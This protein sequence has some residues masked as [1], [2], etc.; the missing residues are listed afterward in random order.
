M[1]APMHVHTAA[2]EPVRMGTGF[3]KSKEESPVLRAEE[4]DGL[5]CTTTQQRA[6]QKHWQQPWDRKMLPLNKHAVSRWKI[7]SLVMQE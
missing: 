4:L 7:L 5:P 1:Y 6:S 3:L 2:R